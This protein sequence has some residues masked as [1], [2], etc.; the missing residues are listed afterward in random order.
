MYKMIKSFFSLFMLTATIVAC[1]TE[2]ENIPLQD[3]VQRDASYYERLRAYK[4]TAHQLAFGWFG[5]WTAIGTSPVKYLSSVPDSVDVISI[6]SKTFYDLDEERKAD[7][8]Y[9]QEQL[10]TRVTYTVFSHNMSNL[11][12]GTNTFENTA[13]N[14]PAAAQA[15]AD[16]IHKYG[17]DGIDFDHECSYK[18][19]FYNATNMTTLL[20]ELRQ[21]IGPDKLILVDGKLDLIT[22]EG[23][24]YV[25]FGVAQSYGAG[26]PSSLQ[27]KY[28]AADE[29]LAPEKFIVTE[30]FEDYW[31]TGGVKYADPELGTVPSLIG[32]ANWQPE[33]LEEGRH[34]GGIGSY[35]MEYEYNHTDVEYKYL[36]QAIQIMNP[37]KK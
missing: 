7:L 37:A 36:R 29:Y 30:N 25:S 20:R 15:L 16:S 34:K 32:M 13:E 4:K 35:H 18:D 33:G 27:S 2:I 19:L 14:I 6:W 12:P 11:F 9:V 31:S 23:W 10:G 24:S 22:E 3:P 8:K 17:Y 26:S 1:D 28:G 5:G 21:H